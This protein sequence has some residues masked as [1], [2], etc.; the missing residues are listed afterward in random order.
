MKKND[1]DIRQRIGS[2]LRALREA[3]GLTVREL[4]D[5]AGVIYSHIARIEQGKYNLQID[6]LHKVTTAL[7]AIIKI[8]PPTK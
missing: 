3:Q 5:K 8:E 1:Y 6:T 7:G 4:A 2:E